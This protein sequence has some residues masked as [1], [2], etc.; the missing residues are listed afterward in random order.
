[1]IQLTHDSTTN[2][3]ITEEEIQQ[4]TTIQGQQREKARLA[5]L[6]PMTVYTGDS[7]QESSLRNNIFKDRTKFDK[8]SFVITQKFQVLGMLAGNVR[9]D[10]EAS[11]KKVRTE[12]A[13]LCKNAMFHRLDFLSRTF[14]KTTVWK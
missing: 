10:I 2:R 5:T 4:A 9:S 12:L 3:H 6:V 8:G 11:K 13:N 14:Y 1:M 7:A